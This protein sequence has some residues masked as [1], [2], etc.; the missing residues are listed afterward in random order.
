MLHEDSDKRFEFLQEEVKQ[1]RQD[2]TRHVEEN[3]KRF[4]FLQEDMVKRFELLQTEMS[5][6]FEASDKRFEFL[7]EEV[8]QLRQD[9]TR[10]VEANDKRFELLQTEMNRRFEEID[11]RFELLQEDMVKRFELLQAEMNRRFE[12][13]E[14]RFEL[15]QEEV[16]QLREDMDRR[17]EDIDKR[18]ELLQ[19]EMNRRFEVSEKRFELLQEEVKQLRE[20]MNRGFEEEK[21][22]R[23][24]MKRRLIKVESTV[25]RM[26]E[27]ITL[28]DAWLNVVTGNVGDKRGQEAEQ[29]FALGLS[30]GLKR[31]DIKPETIQLRQLFMDEECI[32]FPK[33]GKYI[34]VDILAED[35]KLEVFEV[36][37]TAVETDVAIFARKVQLIQH[38]TPDKQ[39]SGIFI[40]PEASEEVKQCCAEYD[41]TFVG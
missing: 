16:K 19:A 9:I 23:L 6:R 30:Y 4:E 17:F 7:L 38:Q 33:K 31:S 18:F 3:D 8:K 41:L 22:E 32:V 2:I 40:S 20:D 11:K 25:I 26:D 21:R 10:H 13:S 24:D 39:V 15:L 35:G 37:I 12:V 14:K 27:K 5:R 34:E 1:L 28:F 29:L 36:K